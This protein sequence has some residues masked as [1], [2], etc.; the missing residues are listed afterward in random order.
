MWC[1]IG[2]LIVRLLDEENPISVREASMLV[3]PH[4]DVELLVDFA[5][6]AQLRELLTA[7]A[8]VVPYTAEIGQSMVTVLLRTVSS[9]FIPPDVLGDMWSWLNRCPVLLP[10]YTAR[11]WGTRGVVQAVRALGDIETLTSYLHLVWSECNVISPEALEDMCD[12]IR[13]DFGGIRVGDHREDLLRRLDY[14]L[15]QL[16]LGLDHL[17]QHEPS[18]SEHDIRRMKRGYGRLKEVLLERLTGK[19]LIS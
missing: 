10:G 6:S 18:L 16:D 1:C 14:V 9:G 19:W 4:L 12:S 17:R 3:S 5:Y 8:S 15:E 11:R 13:K 7:A 2:P